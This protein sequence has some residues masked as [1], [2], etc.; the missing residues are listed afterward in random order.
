M[1]EIWVVR[2]GETDW[3]RT[4]RFQGDLPVPLNDRGRAQAAALAESLR[5]AGVTAVYAS[6]L[7]R[8]AQTAAILSEALG[9]PPPVMEPRLRERDMGPYRGLAYREAAASTGRSL[10]A[11]G[12]LDLQGLP[13]VEDDRAV[14]A[15]LLAAF[16]DIAAALPDARVVAVSHGA[17][18]A[19]LQRT[20]PGKPTATVLGN[21]AIL[22][23][24]RD[25]DEW[26][27]T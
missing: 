15:R 10:N 25:G 26:R 20:L 11:A 27:M 21:G 4:G 22:R 17:A 12:W 5:G 8:A 16:A 18:M 9:L 19:A 3:N 23:L 6:D 2:H 13:G 7:P 1:T 24:R 14:R